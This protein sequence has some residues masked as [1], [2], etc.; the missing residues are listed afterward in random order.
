M[1]FI[2]FHPT[3]SSLVRMFTK[4]KPKLQRNVD[5]SKQGII[6]FDHPGFISKTDIIFKNNIEFWKYFEQQKETG[7][8]LSEPASKNPLRNDIADWWKDRATD[9]ESIIGLKPEN[10]TIDI[11]ETLHAFDEV[12][13][14]FHIETRRV[15]DCGAGVGRVTKEALVKVFDTVDIYERSQKL[16]DAAKD[17][18]SADPHMGDFIQTDLNDIDFKHMYDVVFVNGV[19][20]YFNEVEVVRFLEKVRNSLNPGGVFFLKEQVP[21]RSAFFFDMRVV[22]MFRSLEFTTYLFDLAGFELIYTAGSEVHH[23]V[24]S[25]VRSMVFRSK[26]K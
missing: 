21:T 26:S 16:I 14:R 24:N 23:W 3:S 12:K 2:A 11:Q 9:Y 18:L 15:A 8:P 20:G 10:Q 22:E 7:A 5:H 6:L 19:L 1:A 17:N 25:E 13:S 4:N